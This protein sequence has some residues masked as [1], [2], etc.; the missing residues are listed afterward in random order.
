M[1]VDA[2]TYETL[3]V[4]RPVDGVAVVALNNPPMN[5]ITMQMGHDLKAVCAE[6]AADDAVRAV[7][8][9]SANPGIFCAGADITMM[10]QLDEGGPELFDEFRSIA[11][12]MDTIAALPM[13]TVV[14]IEGIC[15]GGGF[16]L[17]LAC[18]FRF[19]ADDTMQIGLP[20]VRLGLLPGGG[21]TQ[22]LPRLVGA[23]VATEMLMKGMRYDAA[24]AL[25][26]GLLHQ[27]VPAAE[28]HDHAVKYASSLAKQAPRALRHI[29]TLIRTS[30]ATTGS[31][32]LELERELFQDLLT[33]SDVKEGITA[34]TENRRAQFT[35]H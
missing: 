25:E 8:F 21:G 3:D 18:D 7:V 11:D 5:V 33:T 2:R 4:S 9:R 32:G 12:V 10:A 30:F 34:A 22:R 13:P 19:A 29:K 24:T 16:E 26:K 35:G 6:L 23:G 14:A 28:L 20:E 27:V 15:L 31:D 17:S 1:S